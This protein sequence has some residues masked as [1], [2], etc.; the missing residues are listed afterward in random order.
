MDV[1]YA[2][3]VDRATKI[4]SLGYKLVEIWEHDITRMLLNPEFLA[5]FRKF[6]VQ[7]RLKP[8]DAFFGGRTN[9]LKLYHEC[10][11]DEQIK[12]VDYTSLYPWTN[13]Y[14]T[15]PKGHPTIIT[16]EFEDISSYLALQKSKFFHLEH[17]ISLFCR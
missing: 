5:F 8:R 4:K 9:A 13:K 15:Y 2:K 6:D 12:Y 3:T 7:E 16:K 17:C 11:P 10:G 14:A 1:L